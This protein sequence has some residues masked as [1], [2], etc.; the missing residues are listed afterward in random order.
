MNTKELITKIISLPVDDRVI[1]A[2]TIL[3]SLN[4]PES[5]IDKKWV[6]TAKRRAFE[7]SSGKIKAV[8]GDE[9]FNKIWNRLST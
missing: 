4:P 1:I 3:K 9:V 7:L 2:D 5:K 6:A 8:S